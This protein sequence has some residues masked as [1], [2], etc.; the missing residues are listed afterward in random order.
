MIACN[1]PMPPSLQAMSVLSAPADYHQAW[2]YHTGGAM[3]WGWMVPYAIQKGRHRLER[4]GHKD[5]LEKIDEYVEMIGERTGPLRQKWYRHLP[6]SDWGDMLKEMAPYFE[7][8]IRHPD[9]G[10]FWWRANIMRHAES[11]RVPI[12][13]I[14]SWYDIFLEGAPDAYQSIKERSAFP[15]ARRGQKLIMGPWAHIFP[16]TRPTSGSTGE[17]DF[18]PEALISLNDTQLRWFDYW[19]KDVET[20]IMSE[21]PVTVFTMGENQWKNLSD[22]P[23]P[24]VHYI[25]WYLHSGGSANSLEGDGTLS[26]AL[27][28]D[29]P[30]DTFTYDPDDPV[31][32]AGG[33]TLIIPAGVYDQRPAEQRQDVLVFTSEPLE[34]PLEVTGHISVELWAA[35]SACDTDFTAKLVDVHPDGYAQN[36]QDGII[37]ARYRD[38]ATKPTLIEPNKAYKYTIDLWATSHV[39]LRKHRIR[40]D[41]SSSNFPRFDRNQNT[42]AAF[43]EGSK[44][45]KAKQTVY[46]QDDMASHIVLP[47]IPR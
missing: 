1:N 12:L 9:D 32:T 33:N 5:L 2:V 14:G 16:Y 38:S 24:N 41:V 34:K 11:V 35:S 10:E 21:P 17:I 36:L 39:F 30:A 28:G 44:L 6:I 7:D 40:I 22:W 18:G 25:R 37:R 23:P 29:E 13:H 8:Y 42:G 46:H 31:P 20:N 4:E 3:M 26:T 43:G 19:L 47:V 27:P 45:E 15:Q